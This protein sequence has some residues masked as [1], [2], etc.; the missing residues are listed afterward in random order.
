MTSIRVLEY[1]DL[2]GRSPFG[3]WFEGLNAVAAA[4]VTAALYQLGAG[5]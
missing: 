1:V 3:V 4:K 2:L 5:N